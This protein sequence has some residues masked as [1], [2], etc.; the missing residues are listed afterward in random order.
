V[1]HRKHHPNTRLVRSLLSLDALASDRNALLLVFA[2]VVATYANTLFNEFTYDDR[3]YIKENK[4][5]TSL[6][7]LPVIFTKTYAPHD[8]EL[9]VYRPLVEVSYIIDYALGVHRTDLSILTEQPE[10]SP[11]PFHIT[12]MLIHFGV[13]VLLY[14]LVLRFGGGRT[15]ALVSAAMFA[16]HPVHVEVVASVVGRAESLCALF[17]LLSLLFFI[18]WRNA[19][20]QGKATEHYLSPRFMLS[21]LFFSAALL[22]KETAITLPPMLFLTDVLLL[23]TYAEETPPSKRFARLLAAYLPYVALFLLYILIRVLVVGELGTNEKITYFDGKSHAQPAAAM[24]VAFLIYLKLLVLPTILHADYNFPILFV[25]RYF[26]QEP[27]NLLSLWPLIG[28]IMLI[29]YLT[30]SFVL[31]FRKSRL[32]FVL[33]WLPVMLF[34]VS[35]IIPFGDIMAERF[36]YLPSVGYCVLVAAACAYALAHFGGANARRRTA[37]WIAAALVI[38]L[39]SLRSVV[40]NTDWSNEIRFWKA[41]LRT[42]PENRDVYYALG[43]SYA[44]RREQQLMLGNLARQRGDFAAAAKHLEAAAPDEQQAIYYYRV[45]IQKYPDYYQAYY[46]L[47]IL[48][49][50]Q[51]KPDHIAARKV[52]EQGLQFR[53][54]NL[55]NIDVFYFGIG[56]SYA[57]SGDYERAVEFI[58]KALRF[59]PRD[60]KY[61]NNLGSALASLHQYDRA[62]ALWKKALEIEPDNKDARQNLEKLSSLRNRQHPNP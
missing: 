47:G 2:L 24:L 13:C 49:S 14:F 15:V 32:A 60:T 27:K 54:Q 25:D 50:E 61:L 37:V 4:Y 36:L 31:A 43:H 52:F 9:S 56:I 21:I 46:N 34:P 23:R 26:I 1:G 5:I 55:Q 17:Y 57:K 42:A 12:N 28:A 48:L 53:Q 10:A 41:V 29:G 18:S 20:A 40:R 6:R 44:N 3:P 16:V 39:F 30:I 22:S 51:Q 33:L 35:N 45:S 59:K 62:E 11:I 7:Y 8:P 58:E 19:L 38:A